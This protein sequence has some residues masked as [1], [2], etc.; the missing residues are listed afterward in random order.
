MGDLVAKMGTTVLEQ[1]VPILQ[2]RLHSNDPSARRGVC[3]GLK[4]VMA[5]AHKSQIGAFMNDLIPAVRD[6][7][8]DSSPVVREAAGVAFATLF[9]NVGIRA[10]DEIVPALIKRLDAAREEEEEKDYDEEDEDDEEEEASELVLEGMREILRICDEDVLPYLIPALTARP[11]SVFHAQALAGLSDVFGSTFY[12][13]IATVLEVVVEAM[14]DAAAEVDQFKATS[15][16][17]DSKAR[18]SEDAV[19]GAGQ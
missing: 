5:S 13:Y 11:L 14:S 9:H 4:E 3:L 10:I 2:E 15:S 18:A 16:A 19:L 17:S 12:K 1:I 8:C 7:L 6:A